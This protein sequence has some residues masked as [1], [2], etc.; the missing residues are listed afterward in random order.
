MYNIVQE[1]EELGGRLKANKEANVLADVDKENVHTYTRRR[2]AVSTRIGGISTASRFFST[3]EESV[4]TVGASM[5]VSTAGM[6]QEVNIGIPSPVIVKDKG[7]GKM[8]D[9]EDEQSK[10][11]KLQQEQERVGHE[12]AVRL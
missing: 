2:R 9:S 4:S 10:R 7:K 12:A 6:V 1:S 11:T 5:P 8:E 3:A